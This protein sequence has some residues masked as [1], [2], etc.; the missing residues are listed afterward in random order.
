MRVRRRLAKP[1][2]VRRVDELREAVTN[3]PHRLLGRQD[4][5]RFLR[6]ECFAFSRERFGVEQ[7]VQCARVKRLE[8]H[9]RG[10][11]E[12]TRKILARYQRQPQVLVNG[13]AGTMKR[14]L[15]HPLQKILCGLGGCL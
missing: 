3:G 2:R 11:V 6:S 7:K 14:G 1:E 12:D 4:E 15:L 13:E 8:E 10:I 9:V 5:L